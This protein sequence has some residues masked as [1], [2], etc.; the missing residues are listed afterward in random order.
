MTKWPAKITFQVS[1]SLKQA[2]MAQA[3]QNRQYTFNK[4]T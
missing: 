2:I 1:Y 3:L 4:N